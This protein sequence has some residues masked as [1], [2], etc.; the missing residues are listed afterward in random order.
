MATD[1]EAHQARL[2]FDQ[3]RSRHEVPY[4]LIL[5]CET[6]RFTIE[7]PP[8]TVSFKQW[9]QEVDKAIASGRHLV[10]VPVNQ[11]NLAEIEAMGAGLG[12]TLWPSRT[13]IAPPEVPYDPNAK[14][15]APDS[16]ASKKDDDQRRRLLARVGLR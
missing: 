5:D 1:N 14:S 16:E 3:F 7:Q 13:I 8:S 15:D 11:Q 6:R 4:L 2:A 10:C 9:C 12:Y